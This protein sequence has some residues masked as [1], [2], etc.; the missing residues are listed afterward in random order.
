MNSGFPNSLLQ[1]Q[2][3]KNSFIL[4]RIRSVKKIKITERGSERSISPSACNFKLNKNN[5]FDEKISKLREELIK[6]RK[7][8]ETDE[9]NSYKEC[10]SVF[11]RIM[12]YYKNLSI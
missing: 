9:I 12:Y 2:N 11:D 1:I 8:K 6:F 7:G 3:K 5:V 4:P 10:L